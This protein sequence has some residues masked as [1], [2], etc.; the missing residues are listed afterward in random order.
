[1]KHDLSPTGFKKNRR[2]I[3]DA[4]VKAC[5]TEKGGI[6]ALTWGNEPTVGVA[7]GLMKVNGKEMCGMNPPTFFNQNSGRVL[8]SSLRVVPLE[9]CVADIDIINNK[10]RFECTLLHEIVHFVRMRNGIIDP[11]YDL[12]DT[13]EPG[14]QFEIWAYG[15]RLC[16]QDEID[17]ALLS[18]YP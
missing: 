5:G 9:Q 16:S 3:Y 15:K 8:V 4:F 11:D 18:I 7:R 6:K 10:R 2:A 13:E 14:E 1:M 17:D 12:P